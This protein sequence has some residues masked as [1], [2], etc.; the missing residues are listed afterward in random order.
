MRASLAGGRS[1]TQ[2]APEILKDIVAVTQEMRGR[3]TQADV[4][5]AGRIRE[6][7]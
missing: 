3:Q 1:R 4:H 6:D 5:R 7:A 2:G